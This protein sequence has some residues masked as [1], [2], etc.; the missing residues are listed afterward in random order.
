MSSLTDLA[1]SVR[2][3]RADMGLSQATL[4]R[5]TGLSRATVNQVEN[6]SLNDLSLTRTE[7]LLDVLGLSLRIEAARARR[8]AHEAIAKPNAVDIAARTASTSYTRALRPDTLR[9]IVLDEAIPEGFEPHL[10]SLLDE[11]PM[12]LLGQ[13]V[14]QVHAESGRERAG[15]WAALRRLARSLQCGR[16]FWQ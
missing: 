12:S 1:T 16:P 14:E 11:A 3:R 2:A 5:L 7:R 10:R 15:L 8:S 9:R 13:F 4:A 6:G